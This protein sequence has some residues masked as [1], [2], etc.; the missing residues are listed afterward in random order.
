[1]RLVRITTSDIDP[2]GYPDGPPA[3]GT[4]VPMVIGGTTVIPCRVIAAE[5]NADGQLVLTLDIPDTGI[6]AWGGPVPRRG[7][8]PGLVAA[9][10]L[11]A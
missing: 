6:G 9:R 3:V 10:H 4:T 5:T 7:Q 11:A 8:V 1:M 2:A